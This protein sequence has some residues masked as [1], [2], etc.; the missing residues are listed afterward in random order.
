LAT[1][2]IK[3]VTPITKRGCATFRPNRV[4]QGPGNE[5]CNKYCT[6]KRRYIVHFYNNKQKQ[7]DTACISIGFVSDDPHRSKLNPTHFT[8]ISAITS[9]PSAVVSVPRAPGYQY[10]RGGDLGYQIS[11]ASHCCDNITEDVVLELGITWATTVDYAYRQEEI[12]KSDSGIER[13]VSQ[14]VLFD[15]PT[16]TS[17]NRFGI[18]Q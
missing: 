10:I 9:T 4:A 17:I 2:N 14:L 5:E 3:Y 6:H 16:P 8:S 18:R 12:S 13:E 1:N 7:T 11:A 15:V